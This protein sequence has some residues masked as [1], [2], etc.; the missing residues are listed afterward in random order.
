MLNLDMVGYSGA[1]D[2]GSPK[3]VAVQGDDFI[4]KE[5][6]AFTKKLVGTYSQAKVGDM[7]CNYLCSD[8]AA[9]HE[10]GFPSAMIGES[11]YIRGPDGGKPKGYPWIHSENDTIDHV[12]F[13]YMLEFAKVAAAFIVELAY[14]NLTAL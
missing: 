9:A 8:H 1:H 6:T 12:D 11:S 13:D 14:T 4:D 2:A 3:V 7:A 5:L 10:Y